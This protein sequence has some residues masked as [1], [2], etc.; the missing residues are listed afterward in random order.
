VS[1]IELGERFT[2]TM[3]LTGNAAFSLMWGIGGMIGPPVAGAMMSGLG[4][5]GLPWAIAALYL[6][7]MAIG[8]VRWRRAPSGIS[9]AGGS[10]RS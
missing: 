4:P 1:L 6:L 7:V 2:G 8:F 5:N 3:L 10:A 9:S